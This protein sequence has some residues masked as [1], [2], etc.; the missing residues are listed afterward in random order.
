M[1]LKEEGD[2]Y[3]DFP[4]LSRTTPFGTLSEAGGY[5][6]ESRGARI[7]RGIEGLIPFSRIQV[8]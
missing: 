7:W 6:S 8:M 5:P 4:G 1:V 3:E 2:W